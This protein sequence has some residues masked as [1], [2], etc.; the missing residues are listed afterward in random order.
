MQ[1]MKELMQLNL[2]NV[3]LWYFNIIIFIIIIK[4]NRGKS[5]KHVKLSNIIINYIGILLLQLKSVSHLN[6]LF[7]DLI[8][9]QKLR[10]HLHNEMED[11][12][13]FYFKIK[14]IY[15]YNF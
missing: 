10:K 13:G 6:F 1:L 7:R 3:L 15:R 4:Y 14:F 2:H 12:K 9:E 11:M 5:K 8:R